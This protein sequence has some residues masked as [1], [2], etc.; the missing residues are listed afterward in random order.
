MTLT[1]TC[2]WCLEPIE[3]DGY[4]LTQLDRLGLNDEDRGSVVLEGHFPGSR[5]SKDF[6]DFHYPDCF[7]AALRLIRDRHRSGVRSDSPNHRREW[8]EVN[9]AERHRLAL[10][11]LGDG[12]LTAA[13]VFE[14]VAAKLGEDA[15]FYRSNIDPVLRDLL[16]AGEVDREREPRG[17][18]MMWVYSAR[19]ELDGE[20]A[21]LDRAFREGD[22]G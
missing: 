15:R 21:E 3:A 16:E 17:K 1:V 10:D 20:I 9:R 7:H 22:S 6:G 14:R 2:D 12:R 8:R 5:N 13:Q 19:R 4:S 11:A 18:R